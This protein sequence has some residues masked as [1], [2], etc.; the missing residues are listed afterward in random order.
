M[1]QYAIIDTEDWERVSKYK[2]Y[3]ARKYAARGENRNGKVKIY[4]LHHMIAGYQPGVRVDHINRNTLDNRKSNL[5]LCTIAQN[6]RNSEA[7]INNT[8][9]FKG[10]SY[11]KK[12]NKWTA[13]IGYN[14]K[15]IRIGRYKT[16][17]EA[18]KAYNKKAKEL[19][20]DFA[21]LNNI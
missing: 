7:R 14:Y 10:V 12:Q 2:W 21:Y 20:G 8:S 4:Y 11:D 13:Q 9:G 1:G 19:F 3:N 5:R 17:L 16:A 18:A 15:K 6:T